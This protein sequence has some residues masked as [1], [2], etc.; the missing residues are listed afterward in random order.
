MTTT[1]ASA[2]V[3]P[4]TPFRTLGNTDR[5]SFRRALARSASRRT[6]PVTPEADAIYDTLVPSGLTRLAAAMAWIERRNDTND[7]DLVYYGRDLHNVWAVKRPD[8]GWRSYPSYVA[9]AAEWAD[10]ILGPAYADLTTLGE[11]IARYAPWSDGNNPTHYGEKAAREINALPLIEELI[12]EPMPLPTSPT[13]DTHHPSPTIYDLRNNTHA[14]RFGLIPAERDRIIGKKIPGRAG[15]RPEAIGLHVQWG[16]T[17]GSLR[18]WLGVDASATVMVQRD[19]SILNVIPESDG[20][21]TQ[22]DVKTPG[23]RARRLMERFGPDPNVYSLT[24]EAEDERTEQI[25]DVQART[26]LWQIRQWQRQWPHLTD[27]ERI[28]GHYEINSV[29]RA[30]CG[31]YRDAIVRELLAGWPPP[32]PEPEFPGLPPWLPAA[33]LRAAFPLADPGGV[34]TRRLIAWIADAGRLPYYL[35]KRDLGAGRNLWRFD[36]VTVLNDGPRVW[37]EG[38]T[39][40]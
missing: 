24:I 19:G 21:W 9:A 15:M 22:G 30:R 36:R 31:R 11:L 35:E 5:A 1:A 13:P 17:P 6:S 14:A 2:R 25:T 7:A 8:G 4:A 20:P 3:S 34:V 26:I 10:H 33:A 28:L 27:P 32:D 23:P 29:D 38:E 37:V 40:A 12:K 18:H 39:P 16:N